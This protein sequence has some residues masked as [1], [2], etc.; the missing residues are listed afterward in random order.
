MEL[1]TNT[2][3]YYEPLSIRRG[4]TPILI[5]SVPPEPTSSGGLRD[6]N[7]ND[8]RFRIFEHTLHDPDS[9]PQTDSQ[10]NRQQTFNNPRVRPTT[11]TLITPTDITTTSTTNHSEVATR[12]MDYLNGLSPDSRTK[13]DKYLSQKMFGKQ[14]DR[15]K[16]VMDLEYLIK[17]IREMNKDEGAMTGFQSQ[18]VAL[19][20]SGDFIYRFM[21]EPLTTA[22]GF[23]SWLVGAS[24]TA[25]AAETTLATGVVADSSVAIGITNPLAGALLL[26]GSFF[27]ATKKS[28]DAF[29][30]KDTAVDKENAGYIED[31]VSLELNDFLPD[32]IKGLD[33]EMRS[34]LEGFFQNEE[35]PSTEH[36][37]H[38]TELDFGLDGKVQPIVPVN[39][40]VGNNVTNNTQNPFEIIQQI[41]TTG[42]TELDFGKNPIVNVKPVVPAGFGAPKVVEGSLG[43]THK[44]KGAPLQDLKPQAY[45]TGYDLGLLLSQAST[46]YASSNLPYKEII[47]QVV[48][49][50]QHLSYLVDPI[51]AYFSISANFEIPTYET[52]KETYNGRSLRVEDVYVKRYR[53]PD[54]TIR[55]NFAILDE[56]G[57]EREYT[58]TQGSVPTIMKGSYFLGPSSPNNN[59]PTYLLDMFAMLHD[60]GYDNAGFFDLYADLQL[61]SRIEQ[62][63]DRFTEFEKPYAIFTLKYFSSLG[64]LLANFTHKT[65]LNLS[66]PVL[67]TDAGIFDFLSMNN[68][69]PDVRLAFYQGLQDGL[70]V[71]SVALS[72][73]MDA[74]HMLN[75]N[76]IDQ[77]VLV[78]S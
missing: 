3:D 37:F 57:A 67:K 56:T 16:K 26:V 52:I 29:K 18:N 22:L 73:G 74:C 71:G 65:S 31:D 63:M 30:K 76:A 72:Q 45:A 11:T 60:V 20:N 43:Y 70:N 10:N 41:N 53:L 24:A 69:D 58:G 32:E 17:N 62:N 78:E 68:N 8:H 2:D 75:Q 6:N 39:N 48:N 13:I 5:D 35:H 23:G 15:A 54:G 64:Y 55:D 59:A 27:Y 33:S 28:V 38:N 50:E 42:N 19:V 4:Q 36:L 1:Y 47:Q 46:E 44:P 12:T 7:V 21:E 77:L 40:V 25:S 66:D 61:C 9:V 51:N 34:F 49:S 14:K